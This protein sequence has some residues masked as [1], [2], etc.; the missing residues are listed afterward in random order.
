M[1]SRGRYPFS[2]ILFVLSLVAASSVPAEPP[3]LFLT[4]WG[5]YCDVGVS[6]V[7]GCDGQFSYPYGMTV[8]GSGDVYV[9]DTGNHRIQKFDGTGAFLTKC[10]TRGTSAGQFHSP[11]G[12]AVDSSGDV[13]VTDTHNQRVQKFDSSGTF[14]FMWGWGV[15]DGSTAFQTCTSSCQPGISGSGDGQFDSLAGVAVDASGNLYVADLYNHRIQKLGSTG[16]F[17]T[18]WGTHGSSDGQF[19]Y[20]GDVAVDASGN[21]YIADQN[22]NRIQEFGPALDFFIGEPELLSGR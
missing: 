14:L 6:G 4:K 18:K 11:E 8:G 9:A 12:V 7:G 15:D 21:V 2:L 10:G 20:P 16:T 3:P 13:Y 1:N 5:T 17:L 22:N 19:D